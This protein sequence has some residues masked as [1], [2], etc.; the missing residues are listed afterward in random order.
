MTRPVHS[1]D[2][3]VLLGGALGLALAILVAYSG[4]TG[5]DFVGFDDDDYVS[6][7]PVVLKGL[8]GEGVAWAF[9]EGYA[10]NWH[11]LTWLS[12]MVDVTLFG[13]DPGA[14]AMVNVVIHVATS[15]L[16]LWLL[17][18]ITGSAWGAVLAVACFA[19]HPLRVESVAW[20]AERK[21]VLSAL[22]IVATL[23]G[24]QRWTQRPTAGRYAVALG[25]FA[26]ALMA[27]PVAVTVPFVLLLLDVWPNARLGGRGDA[28][29]SSAL[30]LVFEKLPFFGLT[31]ASIAIT[32]VV[33]AEGGAVRDAFFAPFTA[34]VANGLTAYVGYLGATAW[35]VDLAVFYPW[36]AELR[37]PATYGPAL[38]RPAVLG[39]AALLSVVSLL[40][41]RERARRPW[42]GVGFLFFVGTLV[43]ML[44]LV[45]VGNQAMADRYTYLPSMGLALI[46]ASAIAE[47]ERP[48]IRRVVVGVALVAVALLGLAT[49]RQVATW[50]DGET[51][52]RHALA[53]TGDN[54]L[55]HFNLGTLLLRSDPPD[56]A[57]ARTHLEAAYA[58][59]PEHGGVRLNLGAVE[60]FDGRVGEA[61]RHFEAAVRLRPADPDA[62]LS[63][64][65]ARFEQGRV[66]DALEHFEQVA[67][68]TPGDVRAFANMGH[69]LLMSGRAAEA[70]SAFARALE[71]TPSDASLRA[72]LETARRARLESEARTP[73]TR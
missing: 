15:L 26:A 62:H 31:L 56:L 23:A 73:F 59:V 35:P 67:A 66:D 27:K 32:L 4:V 11:P 61:T 58:L 5:H 19:L 8:T 57:G 20:I 38:A 51:L 28:N 12:H 68:I 30:R 22:F 49:S 44:G 25:F 29:P 54:Y 21:D 18:G 16:L 48:P 1:D 3:R 10:A 69:V 41:W 42:L 60:W 55:A 34:R 71:L 17:V 40:C 52:Y 36:S 2:R 64:G 65:S 33:Q 24:W 53:A 9:S 43:P 47:V 70:E 46:L 39:A 45:Q 7:N 13:V 72:G 6:N 14:M 37:D 50:R 63:L